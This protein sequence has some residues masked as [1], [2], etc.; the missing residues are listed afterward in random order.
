MP[1]KRTVFLAFL[2]AA[3][4]SLAQNSAPPATLVVLNSAFLGAWTGELQYRDYQSNQLVSVP[5][6][7][8]VTI[9]PDN[10]TLQFKYLY[11]D[12][13]NKLV[14][15]ISHVT[16]DLDKSTFTVTSEDGK[17]TDNYQISGADK[18][19]PAGLGTL[20]MTGSG[21]ENDKKV[22][23]RITIHIARNA[24]H[25][26]RETRLPGE[27]FQMRDTYNFTRRYPPGGLPISH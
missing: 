27:S 14:Q 24:Y 6:W 22:D 9:A 21:A 2:L 3:V 16:F 12:R 25:Y 13:P 5:T 7:L 18:L 4:S 26:L 8:D 19:S 17:E 11:D 15:E 1:R 20:T 10:R 23:V